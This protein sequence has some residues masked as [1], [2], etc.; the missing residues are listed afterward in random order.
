M[1]DPTQSMR[2]C[3][4]F[5]ESDRRP[6]LNDEMLQNMAHAC[7]TMQ[8]KFEDLLEGG[9]IAVFRHICQYTAR[10]QIQPIPPTIS[11]WNLSTIGLIRLFFTQIPNIPFPA[12]PAMLLCTFLGI[13]L[14]RRY[15]RSLKRRPYQQPRSSEED[16]AHSS[17]RNPGEIQRR[18]SS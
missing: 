3:H 9:Q 6:R 7:K 2:A 1:C 13:Y 15:I 4:L 5:L 11:D 8:A 12:S 16:N 17:N 14:S 18:R 10:H